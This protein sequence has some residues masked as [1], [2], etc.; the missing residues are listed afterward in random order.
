MPHTFVQT[1]DR[2][3]VTVDSRK[4]CYVNVEFI[5]LGKVKAVEFI[6]VSFEGNLKSIEKALDRFNISYNSDTVNETI[7]I[8]RDVDPV[9]LEEVF[10]VL[11]SVK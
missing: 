5:P 3:L 6:I 4:I 10:D 7:K 11:D 8:Y 1:T 2:Y 9:T